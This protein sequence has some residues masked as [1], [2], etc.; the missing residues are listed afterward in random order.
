MSDGTLFPPVVWGDHVDR[1]NRQIRDEP[2]INP[3]TV[4]VDTR[5][6]AP[7]SFQNLRAD[8]SQKYRPLVV[9]TE[10]KG[11]ESGDY[12]IKGYEDQFSIERKSLADAF[13]TFTVDRERF[14]RELERLNKMRF[15]VIIVEA[16]FDTIIAGPERLDRSDRQRQVIGKTVFRSILAWQQRFS[17]VHWC[18]MP[19]RQ[20]AEHTAFRHMQRFWEDREWEKKEARIRQMQLGLKLED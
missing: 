17:R 8:S 13:S 15:A 6:Q 14:E 9:F 4:I 3:F 18:L 7:W 1:S 2:L 5:E 19:G 10:R 20:F 12:T 16:G 11:L